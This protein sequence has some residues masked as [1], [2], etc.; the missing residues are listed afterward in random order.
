MDCPGRQKN[1]I[2]DVRLEL[3]QAKLACPAAQFAP[4]CL[5]IEA[6]L[7]ARINPASRFGGQHNPSFGLA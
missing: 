1:A 6:T 4:E 3:V 7:Q 5:L 2:A